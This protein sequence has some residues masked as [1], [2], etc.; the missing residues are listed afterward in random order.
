MG[1]RGSG[2]A[3][4]HDRFEKAQ[5]LHNDHIQRKQ[6]SLAAGTGVKKQLI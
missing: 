2:V 4:P 6:Q 5:A 1:G 3:T